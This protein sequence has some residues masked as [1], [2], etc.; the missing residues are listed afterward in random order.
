[1]P[2]DQPTYAPMLAATSKTAPPGDG[3]VFEVKWDGFRAIARV[4]GD[5]VRLWSRNG[6]ALDGKGRVVAEALPAALT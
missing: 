5:G 1:M 3:W 4:Q 2:S 6:K